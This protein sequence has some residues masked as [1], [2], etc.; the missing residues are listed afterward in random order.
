MWVALIKSEFAVTIFGP[1]DE[2]KD[3]TEWMTANFSSRKDVSAVIV[4]IKDPK[5]V[6]KDKPIF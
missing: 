1:W 5:L 6:N 4:Q 3:A 2:V